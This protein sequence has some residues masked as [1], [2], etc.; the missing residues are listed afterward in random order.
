MSTE[1]PLSSSSAGASGPG[2]GEL[3]P[4]PLGDIT[5]LLRSWAGG[6]VD[7]LDRLIFR[8]YPELHRVAGALM[9]GEPVYH[10][11][12]ATALVHEVFVRLVDQQYLELGDRTHFLSMA[13]RLM[14]RI[15]IDHAR[16]A[17]ADKR[18]GGWKRVPL[19]A[20]RAST[21]V[22]VDLLDLD[23]ALVRLSEA[24]AF[25]AR[26]VELRFYGGLSIEETGEVLGCS[27]PT[28]VRHWRLARAWLLRELELTA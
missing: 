18:G 2:V 15:L 7:A 16:R 22:S 28:I 1:D 4:A 25:Q 26:L 12:Q 9:A 8:V 17:R 5:A 13:A 20:R 21:N 19:D 24:D 27:R 14:R 11:L 10:T 23:R 6:D 3:P